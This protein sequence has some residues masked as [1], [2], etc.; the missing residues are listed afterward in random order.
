MNFGGYE[1]TLK[2]EP[3]SNINNLKA[4]I[5]AVLWKCGQRNEN[6]KYKFL[7][8]FCRTNRMV[9]FLNVRE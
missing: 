2:Y 8:Y 9:T 3:F 4:E 6:Q 7:T 5:M 1:E